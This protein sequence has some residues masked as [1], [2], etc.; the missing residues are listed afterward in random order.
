[1]QG[2][3]H[4]V[5]DQ[6]QTQHP[7][8]Q[9]SN[10]YCCDTRSP[11]LMFALWNILLLLWHKGPDLEV[12]LMKIS[13]YC[14]DTRPPIWKFPIWKSPFIVVSQ[15]PQFGSLPYENCPFVVVTQSPWFGS[16][17]YKNVCPKV[18]D[19]EVCLMKMY[20]PPFIVLTQGPWFGNLPYE[21]VLL[22]LTQGPRFGRLPFENILLPLWQKVPNFEVCLIFLLYCCDTRSLIL[23]SA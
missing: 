12:C 15:G 14:C 4:K 1:M 16:L 13:F 10:F 23:K 5:P 11:I 19:W 7:W 17:P 18:P 21:N 20:L 2:P 9:A 3:P 6:K 22:L 8:F